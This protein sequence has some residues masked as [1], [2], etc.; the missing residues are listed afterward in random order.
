MS[1]KILITILIILLSGLIVIGGVYAGNLLKGS[2]KWYPPFNFKKLNLSNEQKE[3][4]EEIL[5]ELRGK[6]EEILKKIK[7]NSEKEKVLLSKEVL[8]EKELDFLVE[9]QIKNL[10]DLSNLKK[11][12]YLNIIS[13][14]NK[15][16]RKIFPTFIEF[17]IIKSKGF[18]PDF[19]EEKLKNFNQRIR[20]YIKVG[21][22]LNLSEEQRKNLKELIKE[23]NSKKLKLMY[24]LELQFLKK[25]L[26]LTDQQIEKVKELF[27]NE[28]ENEK[29]LLE[30]IKEN[31][32]KQKEILKSENFNKETLTN[33]INEY[34]L[35]EREVLSLRKSLYLEFVKILTPEQRKNSPTSIFFFKL[36]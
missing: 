13:I 16:Q 7:E 5:K 28:R 17:S 23:E 25:R 24:T 10:I 12:A 6:S 11:D 4:I 8:N 18:M 35:L 9:S 26:N 30:K 14:L 36:F 22:K 20:N 27:K 21:R 15:E 31:N 19:I 3:K 33:L 29:T 1:K 32:Q 34:I 2:Q